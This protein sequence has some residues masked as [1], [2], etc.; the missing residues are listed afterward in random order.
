MDHLNDQ[1]P[2][3]VAAA[4]LD[5]PAAEHPDRIRGLSLRKDQRS[6]IEARSLEALSELVDV[7]VEQRGPLA[8]ADTARKPRGLA[9]HGVLA[10]A[11]QTEQPHAM[12]NNAHDAPMFHPPGRGRQDRR[13]CGPRAERPRGARTVSAAGQLGLAWGTMGERMKRAS[14][15]GDGKGKKEGTRW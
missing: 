11:R 8:P 14:T 10:R 4:E 9:N 13:S 1:P 15:A 2:A 3:P 7:V 6:G 12:R 5:P